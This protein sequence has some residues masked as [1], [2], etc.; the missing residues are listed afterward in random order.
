M[1]QDTRQGSQAV[2]Q[3]AQEQ[4]RREIE[5]VRSELGETVEELVAK[6]DVKARA[7]EKVTEVRSTVSDRTPGSPGEA[8]ELARSKPVPLAVAGG[9][10][11]GVVA[12]L[13]FRRR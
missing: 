11:A 10:F 12:W 9:L 2:G 1:D 3:S 8:A 6:T 7:R 13:L 4:L 5:E